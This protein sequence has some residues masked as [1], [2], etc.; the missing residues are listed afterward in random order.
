MKTVLASLIILLS[1]LKLESQ[2]QSIKGTITDLQ[3]RQPI[4]FANIQVTTETQTS[5]AVSDQEGYFEIEGLEPGRYTLMVSYVGYQDLTLSDIILHAHSSTEL[6]IELVESAFNLEQ[7]TVKPELNKKAAKNELAAVSSRLLSVEEANRYAGGFDD[8]ARLAASFAG[9]SSSI[10]T[11][12]ISIRGNAPKYLQWKMEG[13]EIPNPNHFAD[14]SVTGGGGLTALSS[15]VMDNADFLTGAMPAVYDNALSGVFDL[16]MRR[17]RTDTKEYHLQIGL[18]GIDLASEGPLSSQKNSSY[19]VN[20]RYSTLGLVQSLLPAE[21]GTINYQDLSFKFTFPSVKKGTIEFWGLGLYD[22]SQQVPKD[23]PLQRK[24]I[25]DFQKQ[26]VS[27][28]MGSTGIKYLLYFDNKLKQVLRTQVAFTT[29]NTDLSTAEL[30]QDPILFDKNKIING[31]SNEHIL[32]ELN[33]KTSEKHSNYTGVRVRLMQYNIGLND[34]DEQGNLVEIV[35][36]NGTSELF[37][38]YSNSIF[39]VNPKIN[40]I[41]GFN[42]RYFHLNKEFLTEPRVS[43]SVNPNE[44]M[45]L[46]VGYGLHS[47]LEPLSYYFI[48]NNNGTLINRNLSLSKAHHL[49]ANIRWSPAEHYLLKVEPYYQFL[50]DIPVTEDHRLSF[51]NLENDWFLKDQLLNSGQGRN[52]GLDLTCERYLHKNIYA[53]FTFS[54]FDTKFRYDK[55]SPWFNTRYNSNFGG[56]LLLGK[57][58]NIGRQHRRSLGVNYR[59]AYQGG[60]PYTPVLEE[61]SLEQQEIIF[62]NAHPFTSRFPA[63]WVHHFTVNYVVNRPK[64][65]HQ[66]SLKILNLGGYREFESFRINFISNQIEEYREALVI[67]NLSYK[68]SF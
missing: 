56:N 54:I 30:N 32:I 25:Q 37:N 17:G 3:S 43:L 50:F 9:V 42:L 29:A 11:N 31:Q 35:S 34:A 18:I 16:G 24:Y 58:F 57:E 4:S 51:I 5:G 60:S 28:Y 59:I 52:L 45:S 13:I 68:V 7:I 65:T 21:A 22:I 27:Q 66:W 2:T 15:Q 49:I 38:F 8:P 53:M 26:N 6:H 19:I 48:K 67:P 61:T 55:N 63:A 20:Y 62:D 10:Q 1:I 64:I 39:R 40:I 36:E 47:R 44:K 46:G 33:T 14:L 41:G 23:D 12:G